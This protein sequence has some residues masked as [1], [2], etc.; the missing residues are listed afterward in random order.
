VRDLRV[1][2]CGSSPATGLIV[3]GC[4]GRC[5]RR[6]WGLEGRLGADRRWLEQGG[7]LSQCGSGAER[8]WRQQAVRP[9]VGG[10]GGP[11][12]ARYARKKL[13]RRRHVYVC[14]VAYL[15]RAS[16]RSIRAQSGARDLSKSYLSPTRIVMCRARGWDEMARDL[17]ALAGEF[18]FSS[19]FPF[20]FYGF[21]TDFLR[22]FLLYPV[23]RFCGVR[24]FFKYKIIQICFFRTRILFIFEICLN[25]KFVLISNFCSYLNFVHI[26]N[27]LNLNFVQ[28]RIF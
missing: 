1:L 27:C 8:G 22:I 10:G 13:E 23:L 7:A 18:S 14:Q 17:L 3:W 19:T 12:E 26:R 28:T 9:A 16:N 20:G 24:T 25:S 21:F 11:M 2:G 6:R 15:H 5:H 4:R